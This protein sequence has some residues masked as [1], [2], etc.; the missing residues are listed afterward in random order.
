MKRVTL[1]LPDELYVALATLSQQQ[2][3]SLHGQILFLLRQATEGL[4]YAQS[5]ADTPPC[6]RDLE[7]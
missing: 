3:R 7:Q 5:I 1:R 4:P 2:E 6:D